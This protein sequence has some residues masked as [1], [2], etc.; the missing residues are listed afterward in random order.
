MEAVEAATS[1]SPAGQTRASTIMFNQSSDDSGGGWPGNG[2]LKKM[3]DAEVNEG[4]PPL[5]NGESSSAGTSPTK[6]VSQGMHAKPPCPAPDEVIRLPLR[7]DLHGAKSRTLLKA[8]GFELT[9][10]VV[11]AGKEI[12]PHKVPT[13][14]TVQCLEGRI[15]FTHNGSTKELKEGELLHL[16][17]GEEHSVKGL[18]DASLLLTF[19][20]PFETQPPTPS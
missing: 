7:Q 9:R 14:V 10:L 6:A 12:M 1:P 15:A 2:D 4:G 16:C 3:I 8:K 18:E 19:R 5:G 20:L 17:P 11:P 13:E